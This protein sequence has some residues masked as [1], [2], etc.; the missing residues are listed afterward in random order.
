[1]L[2]GAARVRRRGRHRHDRGGGDEGARLEPAAGLDAAVRRT[3]PAAMP[4]ETERESSAAHR[5][6]TPR[7]LER[8]ASEPTTRTL[9][10]ARRGRD[11]AAGA[12]AGAAAVGLAAVLLWSA[13]P[14]VV[15]PPPMHVAV[16]MPSPTTAS[17]GVLLSPDGR[18]L[19]TRGP[20]GAVHAAHLRRIASRRHSM[21][22][23]DA[24]RQTAEASRCCGPNDELVRMDVAGGPAV[25]FAKTRRTGSGCAWGRDGVLLVHGGAEPFSRADDFRRDAHASGV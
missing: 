24:G 5:R 11:R 4:G 3:A 2:T 19:A 8:P 14:A 1:M 6:R 9:P 12:V 10:A 15:A 17:N 18:Y 20:S 21:A 16:P 7:T 23:P 25:A 22:S 13:T